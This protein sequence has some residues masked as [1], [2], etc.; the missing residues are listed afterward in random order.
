VP[1][2]PEIVL[3]SATVIVLTLAKANPPE[4]RT[5]TNDPSGQHASSQGLNN[6]VVQRATKE[7]MR[8]G[9]QGE[10]FCTTVRWVINGQL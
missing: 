8:M 10:P 6:L 4:V 7:W 3:L 5:N 1:G 2:C 9:N